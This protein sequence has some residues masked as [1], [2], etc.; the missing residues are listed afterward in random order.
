M[1]RNTALN[2]SRDKIK[3]LIAQSKMAKPYTDEDE[4]YNCLDGKLD[5]ARIMDTNA[6]ILLNEYFKR[7]P[8]KNIEDYMD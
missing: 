4:E 2:F 8:D 5:G 3:R 1:S 7:N 6:Q